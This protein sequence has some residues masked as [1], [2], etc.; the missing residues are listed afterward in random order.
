MQSKLEFNYIGKK[1]TELDV[2]YIKTIIDNIEM[3]FKSR[4]IKTDKT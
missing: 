1:P 3:K 4:Y 2:L